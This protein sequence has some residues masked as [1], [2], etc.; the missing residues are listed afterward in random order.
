MSK[1]SVYRRK[2]TA[3]IPVAERATIV[4]NAAPTVTKSTKLSAWGKVGIAALIVVAVLAIALLIV[5]IFVGVIKDKFTGEDYRN[6]VIYIN[7]RPADEDMDVYGEAFMNTDKYKDVYNDVLENY[8]EASHSIRSNANIY[9]FAIY[10]INNFGGGNGVA[11]LITIV[12]FDK[13]T[14]EVKYFTIEERLLVYIPEV[15]MGELKDAYA[16]SSNGSALL[17]KTIKQN[18]GIEIN[19]YI[20]MNM[21]AASKLIDKVGGIQIDANDANALNN[22]INKYNE[23]FGKDAAEVKVEG[24]KAT[25]N[26][27]QSIAYVRENPSELK[28]I[29]KKLGSAIFESGIGGLIDAVNIIAEETKSTITGNDFMALVSI[30]LSVKNAS[31][32]IVEIGA[33]SL[34]NFWYADFGTLICDYQAEVEFL[35]TSIYG[36]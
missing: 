5:N 13:T 12:S 35:Q 34:E 9:N 18:F 6:E 29:V 33:S 15:G 22:A 8:A 31:S 19:G 30:A 16:W 4:P 20:E 7:S 32:E 25:L 11:S 1:K 23:R 24:G 10:G 3:N 26:G 27:E 36:K 28:T 2:N 14:K 17:T 21:A